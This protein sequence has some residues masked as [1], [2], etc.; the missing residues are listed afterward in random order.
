MRLYRWT[1]VDAL[2]DWA[3]GQVIVMARS[4]EEA[5]G[6]IRAQDEDGA[7]ARECDRTEPEVSEAPMAVFIRGSA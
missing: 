4:L 2:A 6:L 1:G 3:H 5:R 7:V